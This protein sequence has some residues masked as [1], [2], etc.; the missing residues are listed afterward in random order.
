M[1]ISDLDKLNTLN[2]VFHNVFITD[3]GQDL[4]LN[5]LCNIIKMNNIKVTTNDI[6]TALADMSNKISRTPDEIPA[7]FFKR[8]APWII[9]VLRHL[10]QLSLSTTKIPYQWKQALIVIPFHKKGTRKLPSNYRP[11]SLPTAIIAIITLLPKNC[12]I[13]Y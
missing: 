12:Y 6:T 4:H 7:F 8:I 3:N 9:D 1:A 11:I 13:I 2:S 10:Y 5:E